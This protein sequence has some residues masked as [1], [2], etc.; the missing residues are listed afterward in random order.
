MCFVRGSDLLSYLFSG[1]AEANSLREPRQKRIIS[2]HH[3]GSGDVEE[4]GDLLG[5]EDRAD[6]HQGH[7]DA[8][9]TQQQRPELGAVRNQGRD[10]VPG[11]E[12]RGQKLG[13]EPLGHGLDIGVGEPLAGE[14]TLQG[15]V[16]GV[17]VKP[18]H[19]VVCRVL[20]RDCQRFICG[21][22]HPFMLCGEGY[23]L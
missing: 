6:G 18:G 11:L 15:G 23:P 12:A 1:L 20:P 8:E 2:D 16:G 13:A 9:G 4:A 5:A 17:L 14:G 3:L 22:V 21:L 7:A 19:A 10:P